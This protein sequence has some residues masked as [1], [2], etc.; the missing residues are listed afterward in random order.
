M[1]GSAFVARADNASFAYNGCT[2]PESLVRLSARQNTRD[3]V[4]N[5]PTSD[6][7]LF[8]TGSGGRVTG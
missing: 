3:W 6:T 5:K 4:K 8:Y 1:H 2:L 7:G